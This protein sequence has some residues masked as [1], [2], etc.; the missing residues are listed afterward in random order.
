MNHLQ[1]IDSQVMILL[2]SRSYELTPHVIVIEV[3]LISLYDDNVT[4]GG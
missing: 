2:H 3:R 1:N 4:Q